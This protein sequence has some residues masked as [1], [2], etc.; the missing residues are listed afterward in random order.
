MIVRSW[1]SPAWVLNHIIERILKV[2]PNNPRFCVVPESLD[3]V[4]PKERDA[5]RVEGNSGKIECGIA[6]AGIAPVN[7]GQEPALGRAHNIPLVE[8]VV[9][10]A[11]RDAA[12][13]DKWA[14]VRDEM[15]DLAN[16]LP[17]PVTGVGE[18][19]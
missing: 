17:T 5:N 6:P 12:R 7:Q 9:Q 8:V 18:T 1:N 15:L 10:E 4:I 11:I 14:E 2:V 13:E 3:G 19:L 16:R